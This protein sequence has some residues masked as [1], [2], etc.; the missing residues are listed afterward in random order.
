[1]NLAYNHNGNVIEERL[2]ATPGGGGS[3]Q[4]RM[5][6]TPSNLLRRVTTADDRYSEFHYGID[7][8]R[9]IRR[10]GGVAGVS[11]RVHYIGNVEAIYDGH[12]NL[13]R[14]SYQHRDHLGSITA[15]SNEFG[16]V[17]ARMSFDPWGKRRDPLFSQPDWQPWREPLPGWALAMTAWTDRG[18]TAHEHLDEHGIV[19]MNGRIYDPHLGRFLQADPLIEDLATLNRYTYVHNNPL[20]Y[21]DPSGYLSFKD[22]LKIA[23]VVVITWFTAG[24]AGAAGWAIAKAGSA[25]AYAIVAAGGA[26]S[27]YIM[28]GTLEGALW[29]AF[30]GAVFY[31]IGQNLPGTAGSDG[32]LGTS[33]SSGELIRASAAHG[34]AGGTI[35]ELQGGKFGHGFWS[36]GISK[37]ASPAIQSA[38][39]NTF[40][41]GAMAAVV[42]GSVSRMTGGKFANG[43]AT[44]AMAYAFN[45]LQSNLTRIFHQK[46]IGAAFIPV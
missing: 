2:A 23:A 44:A 19:H 3:E 11:R 24:L 15:L 29:G 8:Q 28:T 21:Y 9:V 46:S 6:Y 22:V 26:L 31:G 37:I 36:A 32:V 41:Q 10:D 35:S 16:E 40:A 34:L 18:F 5:R 7:R 4:R 1:M 42:G 13:V 27:G 25:A 45:Q 39:A 20:V 38:N 43:A 17:I 14:T 33:Y 30:S 12:G